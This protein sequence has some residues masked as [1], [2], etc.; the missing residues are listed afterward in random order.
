MEIVKNVCLTEEHLRDVAVS[1]VPMR[2]KEEFIKDVSPGCFDK[3]EIGT[4]NGDPLPPFYKESAVRKHRYMTAALM[5]LY[6]HLSVDLVEDGGPW[7]ITDE[8]YEAASASFLISQLERIKKRT[9]DKELQDKIYDLLADYKLLEKL[10]NAEC[11][12]ML[13]AMNDTVSRFQMMMSAQTTPEAM[14]AL[15]KATE[16]TKRELEEYKAARG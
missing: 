7:D 8:T 12:G 3:M 5:K 13:P 6:L 11:Y 4:E 9:A 14:E 1:Y 2:D 10:L 15:L 16:E